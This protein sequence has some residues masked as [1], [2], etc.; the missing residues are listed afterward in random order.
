MGQNLLVFLYFTIDWL[1]SLET[2]GYVPPLTKEGL[3]AC[4]RGGKSA[5]TARG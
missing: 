3:P 2:Y 5:K 4:V 1:S